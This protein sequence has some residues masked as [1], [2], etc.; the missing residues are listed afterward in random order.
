MR[1]E[2][3]DPAPLTRVLGH[4][5]P[6]KPLQ[7]QRAQDSESA[8]QSDRDGARPPGD[9]VLHAS[10]ASTPLGLEVF[11]AGWRA[12]GRRSP[13]LLAQPQGTGDSGNGAR[14]NSLDSFLNLLLQPDQL[15]LCRTIRDI[16]CL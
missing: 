3:L 15:I 4:I 11:S 14:L 12:Q 7:M 16:S 1:Q 2:G 5:P 13:V 8:Y 6:F 10:T 9:C